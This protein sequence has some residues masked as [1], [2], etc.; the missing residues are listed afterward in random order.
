MADAKAAPATKKT[1]PKQ[2]TPWKPGQSGNPNGRPKGARTKLA[3]D[4]FNDVL[5][6]WKTD[7]RTAVEKTARDHPEKFLTVVA[8]LVPKQVEVDATDAAVD[9]AKGLH[10]VAEFLES[11]ADGEGSAD[12]ARALPD[13]SV[14]PADLR[15]QTH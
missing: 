9:L 2:L 12:H 7:G 6:V 1:V 5:A 10:A 11:L 15:P 14:L 8:G 13:G 4:F 3:N